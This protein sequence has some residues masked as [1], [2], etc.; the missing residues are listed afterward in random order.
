MIWKLSW[1]LSYALGFLAFLFI[2]SMTIHGH[3]VGNFTYFHN[4]VFFG[5]VMF[6]ALYGCAKI[7]AVSLRD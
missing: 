5:L 7:T 3:V 2:W 6:Y 4:Q 1:K